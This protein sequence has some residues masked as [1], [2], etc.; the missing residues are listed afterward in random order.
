[1]RNL[2]VVYSGACSTGGRESLQGG[3]SSNSTVRVHS[4]VHL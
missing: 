3:N 1:M 4:E 2:A